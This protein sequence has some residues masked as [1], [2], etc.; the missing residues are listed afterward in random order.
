MKKSLLITIPAILLILF[1]GL[2]G[3][4][5]QEVRRTFDNKK[6]VRLKTF[7]G[8]CV[9]KM[10]EGKELAV[11]FVHTYS[12][13]TFEPVFEE[14]GSSLLLKEKFHIAESG[15][16]TWHLSVPA[17]IAVQ[18]SSISGDF[19]VEGLQADIDAVTVS[20]DIKAGNCKGKIG[21]KTNN[22]DLT[23][24][25]LSGS[26]TVRGASSDLKLSTLTGTMD[27]KTGSGDVEAEQ[28]SGQV[29]LKS[30]SG[31]VRIKNSRGV[32]HIKTASGEVHAT[33]IL[34]K[35]VSEFK[36]TSGDIY[37]SL[38][39]TLAHDLTAVTA[40]G[41]VTLNYN[42]HPVEG[43]FK[44]RANARMGEMIA[45]YPFEN[46]NADQRW[47]K[48]YVIKSFQRE[49]KIPKIFLSTTSGTLE[50]KEK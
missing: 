49:Y 6:S 41:D 25:G 38:V 18:Y 10:A 34:F 46:E 33:D 7:S 36:T 19:S 40:S 11:R 47:G 27:I 17:G 1:T 26:L 28:L 35:D 30:P 24:E 9:V 23:A 2:P 22:G 20:G 50:L 44:F 12:N 32:F 16:S 37:I 21:L 15:N 45:P 29:L 39:E 31:D 42:G 3:Q 4:D 43:F 8:D 14:S 48:K 5:S 13:T